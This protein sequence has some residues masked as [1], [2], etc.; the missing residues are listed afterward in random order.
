MSAPQCECGFLMNPL[1]SEIACIPD[2]SG[3]RQPMQETAVSAFNDFLAAQL[4]VPGQAR[5]TL[6]RLDDA[7]EVPAPHTP[8][9]TARRQRRRNLQGRA[10]TKFGDASREKQ[11]LS[12]RCPLLSP[13]PPTSPH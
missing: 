1:L 10:N 3:S 5:L 8:C 7:C 9:R 11:G 4:T 12:S 2:R 6:V 13:W